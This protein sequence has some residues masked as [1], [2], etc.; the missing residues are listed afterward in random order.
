MAHITQYN[1]KTCICKNNQL[2]IVSS[3]G[4]FGHDRAMPIHY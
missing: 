1:I 2:K 4:R 3:C